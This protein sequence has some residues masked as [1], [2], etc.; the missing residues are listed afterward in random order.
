MEINEATEASS[1]LS[2]ES[3]LKV[4]K[5]LID[6]GREGMVPG[7]LAEELKIP[8]NTLSFLLSYMSKASLVSS[9]KN[10]RS[11]VCPRK[12]LSFL[13]RYLTLWD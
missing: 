7:K 8:D 2:R 4:F 9:K 12:E 1:S 11:V 13:D 6:Y 5:L 10:G 3:R